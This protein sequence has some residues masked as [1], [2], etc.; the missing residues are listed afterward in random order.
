MSFLPTGA[1]QGFN[2]NSS[3]Y[4]GEFAGKFINAAFQAAP[5]LANANVKI[6]DNIKFQ[7]VIQDFSLAALGGNDGIVLDSSCDYADGLNLNVTEVV[8]T[9]AELQT[10]LTLCKETFHNDWQSKMQK[11]SA[12]DD[13]PMTFEQY[14][15]MYIGGRIGSEIETLIWSG[16][17][18]TLGDGFA[19]RLADGL[20]G[21]LASQR[22]DLGDTR[23]EAGTVKGFFASA[24][25]ALPDRV[26]SNGPSGLA[27][28]VGTNV[29]KAYVASLGATNNGIQD[30]Q[31]TWWGGNFN[32]LTYDGIPV[33]YAPGLDGFTNGATT[34]PD[35]AIVLTYRDNLIFGT[36]LMNDYNY[37]DVIDLA[38]IDGSRNVRVV[39][40][41]TAG[42]QIGNIEDA[43][44]ATTTIA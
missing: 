2:N 4:T 11:M 7:S 17:G 8:I 26:Y 21:G 14:M 39:Y 38:K 28:Y 32:G 3:T 20:T 42:T 18:S 16:Q 12:H 10:T 6:M 43:V 36:G 33:I 31:T 13:V 9:P 23:A 25:D 41:Y 24:L 44:L 27:F 1:G 34:S 30:Y 37:A 22:I 19:Q 15:L 35:D 5:T 40:R 29:Y